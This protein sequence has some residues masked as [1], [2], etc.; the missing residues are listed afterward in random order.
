MTTAPALWA[1][2]NEEED[3]I[4]RAV[5]MSLAETDDPSPAAV[6]GATGA[7]AAAQHTPATGPELTPSSA[8]DSAP[9]ATAGA[10]TAAAGQEG[11]ALTPEELRAARLARFG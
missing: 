3:E 8:E 1:P 7:T 4:Q 11:T 2:L 6:A 5:A 9:V 10:N